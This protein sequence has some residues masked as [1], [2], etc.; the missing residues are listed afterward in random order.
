MVPGVPIS[1]PG[2]TKGLAYIAVAVVSKNTPII[3]E[4][5]DAIIIDLPAGSPRFPPGA[6]SLPDSLVKAPEHARLL[7]DFLVTSF[8]INSPAQYL[9]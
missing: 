7:L 2:F 3:N 1:K 4:A 8:P 6:C 9:L 5:N